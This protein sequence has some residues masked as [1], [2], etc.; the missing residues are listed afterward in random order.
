MLG[1]A[2]VCLGVPIASGEATLVNSDETIHLD[3][4]VGLNDVTSA[5]Y[6]NREMLEKLGQSNIDDAWEKIGD[7]QY[8]YHMSGINFRT[9]APIALY[10][11]SK[12]TIDVDG[13]N[14][15]T[16]ECDK[17]VGETAGV[18]V[19]RDTLSIT[20][21]NHSGSVLNV[22]N[23]NTLPGNGIFAS[24]LEVTNTTLSVEI[25]E[26]QVIGGDRPNAMI[27]SGI[28]SSA[29]IIGAEDST[30]TQV[31][32]SMGKI[33][34]YNEERFDSFIMAYGM[35]VGDLTL[36]GKSTLYS[37]APD[38][39]AKFDTSGST[40][41]NNSIGLFIKGEI[42]VLPGEKPS[43]ICHGGNV[44]YNTEL[45][46][47][48]D[49]R[50]YSRG[51]WVPVINMKPDNVGINIVA[52][53]G[54]VHGNS[55]DCNQ[56]YNITSV[57]LEI[58]KIG[59]IVN[60]SIHAT[61]SDACNDSCDVGNIY[62]E[63]SVGLMIS[64]DLS[65]LN[66]IFDVESNKCAHSRS[67][68]IFSTGAMI[69]N[70]I[71]EYYSGPSYF[72]VKTNCNT[73]SLGSVG[74]KAG[75]IDTKE[76]VTKVMKILWFDIQCTKESKS[77]AF[78]LNDS[79]S[80]ESYLAILM[81]SSAS[82]ILF[83]KD[84]AVVPATSEDPKL[85]CA[86]TSVTTCQKVGEGKVSSIIYS[87]MYGV[88]KILGESVSSEMCLTPAIPDKSSF[89]EGKEFKAW[90]VSDSFGNEVYITTGNTP[91]FNTELTNGSQ[92]Q[93][94]G[95]IHITMVLK[96]VSPAPPADNSLAVTVMIIVAIIV[97][98]GAVSIVLINK[99]K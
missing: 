66:T 63:T 50:S 67:Y 23:C 71:E 74:I 72:Y 26:K 81:K 64:G 82:Q 54:Y 39:I 85:I 75:T 32:V 89:P 84:G 98:V 6:T 60:S 2:L 43:I 96:D 93:T 22:R 13:T 77:C 62:S 48:Y 68:G 9:I 3:G 8:A 87:D 28:T 55:S 91:I 47:Q 92:L 70:Y 11:D 12:L 20:N 73:D 37:E 25:S 35:N 38:M 58:L 56:Q 18:I 21:Y 52:E 45:Q 49:V 34:I 5:G 78:E 33:S 65:F 88:I 69:T 46:D 16:T 95:A 4:T 53:A 76:V 94:G 10:I 59:A 24:K 27:T 79:R 40:F 15:L 57:G 90:K 99:M 41:V 42:V 97:A 36:Q 19:V 51:I 31:I 80:L 83:M 7:Q 14:T 44:D 1:S 29:M 30:S 61:S 86:S 17:Y